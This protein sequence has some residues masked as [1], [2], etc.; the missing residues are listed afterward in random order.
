ML[1][2][3]ISLPTPSTCSPTCLLP[4]KLHPTQPPPTLGDLHAYPD[5]RDTTG[6]AAVRGSS[7]PEVVIPPPPST[8]EVTIGADAE[9]ATVTMSRTTEWRR[10][11]LASSAVVGGGGDGGIGVG[12]SGGG[13]HGDV[14]A[15]K[16]TKRPRKEYSCS[17]CK[18]SMSGT[19]HLFSL[20]QFWTMACSG[21]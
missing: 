4:P 14:G 9:V 1:M 3:G 13:A 18:K 8:S 11:K 20:H 16:P 19:V 2:Q 6:M 15:G 21:Q 7:V 10:R 12:R 17:R 5:V